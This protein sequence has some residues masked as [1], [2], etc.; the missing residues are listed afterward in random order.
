MLFLQ[1]YQFTDTHLFCIYNNIYVNFFT[2]DND[3]LK[4][5]KWHAV[6]LSFIFF[7]K[8]ISKLIL[9]NIWWIKRILQSCHFA[10]N[11]VCHVSATSIEIWLRVPRA[12]N[13]A[14]HNNPRHH[15]SRRCAV[16]NVFGNS[17]AYLGPS[18]YYFPTIIFQLL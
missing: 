6:F 8:C 14:N 18:N 9:I 4:S 3:D 15:S 13:R 7:K 5:S 16:K 1:L 12:A 2:F 17:R 10:T 11:D